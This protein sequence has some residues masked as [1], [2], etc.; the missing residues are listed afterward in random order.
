MSSVRNDR[1]NAAVYMVAA[2]LIA[3]LVGLLSLHFTQKRHNHLPYDVQAAYPPD[4]QLVGGEAFAS[5]AAALIDHELHG[6]S[7]WRP[8]DFFLW[9]MT[10]GPDNNANRQLGIIQALRESVRIFK[11]HLTKISSNEYDANLVAADLTLRNDEYKFMLPSAESKFEDGMQALRKYVSGLE[12]TPP[13]SKPLNR[14]NIELIRLFQQW[15]DQLGDA[16]AN[17]FKETEPD[18]SGVAAWHTDNYFYHAQG[19]AH[20]MHHLTKAIRREYEK[21]LASRPGLLQ[22]FDEVIAA[23]GRGA[24]LKP[25]VVIDGGPDNIFANHR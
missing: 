16:H 3:L 12:Q 8:N 17:L 18:G 6:G 14:R 22:V 20:V 15:S 23:L 21:E 5:T 13:K 1:G 25:L 19:M 10:L 11:D 7:G 4:K 24:E 2:V 9:G